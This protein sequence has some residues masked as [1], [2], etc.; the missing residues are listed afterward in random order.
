M[1][2]GSQLVPVNVRGR[3]SVRAGARVRLRLGLDLGSGFP[4]AELTW[5]Q[6]DHG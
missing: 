2:S 5:G 1:S 3:V 6:P 4:W